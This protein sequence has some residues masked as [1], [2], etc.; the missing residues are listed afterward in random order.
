MTDF[1]APWS[2][3]VR[4]PDHPFRFVPVPRERARKSGWS[5]DRQHAFIAAL[6]RIPSVTK[7]ARS[8]GMSA[9]SA[10]RL[11]QAP[12]ADCFAQAWDDALERGIDA[13]R[14]AALDLG[15]GTLVPIIDRGRV[16][17]VRRKTNYRLLIAVLTHG[18]L[19]QQG[20]LAHNSAIAYRRSVRE[21]DIRWGGPMGADSIA[22]GVAAEARAR[23]EATDRV[24]EEN[25][26]RHEVFRAANPPRRRGPGLYVL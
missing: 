15:R 1:P 7:A 10:Y 13:A 25:A 18:A 8:V 19:E 2:P 11:R 14:D 5:S 6:A 12:G 20:R 9:R 21:A 26:A 17:G 22:A 23:Q 3:P 16:I 24:G 4:L